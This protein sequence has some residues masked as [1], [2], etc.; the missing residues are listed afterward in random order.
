MSTTKAIL[1]KV[2]D[3]LRED[4]TLVDYLKARV[5]LG[6]R[7]N[8]PDADFP[9]VFI[10]PESSDEEDVSYPEIDATLRILLAGYTR[11][12]DLE[13]QVVGDANYKGILDL[14]KDIKHALG[15][16]LE[17][18]GQALKVTFPRTDF[19]LREDLASQPVRTVLITVAVLYRTNLATRS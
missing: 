6:D 5:H 15:Q 2:R 17:L 12:F 14:E 1:E 16:D 11:A 13:A 9:I 19:G 7:K 4:A 18:G 3:V 8:V 10:E